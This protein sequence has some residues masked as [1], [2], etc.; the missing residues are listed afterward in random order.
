ME[1]F[2]IDIDDSTSTIFKPFRTFIHAHFQEHQDVFRTLSAMSRLA[3]LLNTFHRLAYQRNSS[4]SNSPVDHVVVVVPR[5]MTHLRVCYQPCYAI[6]VQILPR[7][8]VLVADSAYSIYDSGNC[9]PCV[10]SVDEFG[11]RGAV[12]PIPQLTNL[13]K[14]VSDLVDVESEIQIVGDNKENEDVHLFDGVDALVLP[15][16]HG[17]VM[18]SSLATPAFQIVDEHLGVVSSFTLILDYL[19][20]HASGKFAEKNPKTIID[21]AVRK[22]QLYIDYYVW[23]ATFTE[24]TWRFALMVGR[25]FKVHSRQKLRISRNWRIFH[26]K[27]RR[28]SPV[29]RSDEKHIP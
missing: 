24:N 29:Q 12:S 22:V 9:L 21:Y 15:L 13:I 23:A 25:A 6:D 2:S 7:G 17:F 11:R 16:P 3:P 1:I 10:D 4:E 28:S 19:R 20:T 27:P 8:L 18:H 14:Q 26:R 5:S